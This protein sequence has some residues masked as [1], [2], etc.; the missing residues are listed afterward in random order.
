MRLL[1]LKQDEIS[2]MEE[3]LD[4]IDLREQRSLFLGCARRDTNAERKVVLQNLK[5]S[6]SEY[7]KRSYFKLAPLKLTHQP[8]SMLKEYHHALDLTAADKRDV[9]S[10][11][12]WIDGTGCIQRKESHYLDMQDDLLNLTGPVDGAINRVETVIED[13]AVWIALHIFKVAYCPTE[14]MAETR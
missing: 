7:G 4:G 9:S 2:V 11:K 6:L 10:I 12:H 13:C 3:E 1:L 14:P 5:A 8:D